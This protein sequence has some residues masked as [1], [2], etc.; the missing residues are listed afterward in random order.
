MAEAL[1]LPAPLEFRFNRDDFAALNRI[2][3]AIPGT[4]PLRWLV[5]AVQGGVIGYLMVTN[6]DMSGLLFLVVGLGALAVDRAFRARAIDWTFKA[7]P[8]TGKDIVVEFLPDK[9]V[10]RAGDLRV[11]I[12]WG[13]IA[14]L[15]ETP[16]HLFLRLSPQMTV[17]LPRR[18]FASPEEYR[19]THDF[20]AARVAAAA[21]AV[22][23]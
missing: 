11:E 4:K 7:N 2:T 6:V 21:E 13:E 16:S 5:T 10:D 8:M 22:K 19:A 23:S 15:V 1:E 20:I 3:P 18:V 17:I 12:G 9:L 14:R